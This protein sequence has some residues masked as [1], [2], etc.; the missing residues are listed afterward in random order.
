MSI[1]RLAAAGLILLCI[2]YLRL[3]MPMHADRFLTALRGMIG[4]EQVEITLPE[5]TAAWLGWR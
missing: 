2:F 1:K 4:Q 5:G 3:C